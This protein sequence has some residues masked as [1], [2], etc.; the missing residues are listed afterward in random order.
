M[1]ENGLLSEIFETRYFRTT[2]CSL[3]Y[4]EVEQDFLF[5]NGGSDDR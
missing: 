4:Q 1:D 3:L 2:I 5:I